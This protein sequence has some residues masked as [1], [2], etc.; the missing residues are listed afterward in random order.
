M[1]R[2]PMCF[3]SRKVAAFLAGLVA[4]IVVGGVCGMLDLRAGPGRQRLLTPGPS[5]QT[6]TPTPT[7]RQA[8][9]GA[10]GGPTGA[11]SARRPSPS[12]RADS[13]EPVRRFRGCRHADINGFQA[14]SSHP[15][16]VRRRTAPGKTEKRN[17][18]RFPTQE[19]K[20]SYG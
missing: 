2:K 14:W 1:S 7:S 19:R 18:F 20:E 6:G 4:G 8:G 17:P 10:V 15:P 5:G 3:A 12:R 9:S 13:P 11:R 16:R